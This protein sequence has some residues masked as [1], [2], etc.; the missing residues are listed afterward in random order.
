MK[1]I[2]NYSGIAGLVLISSLFFLFIS[3]NKDTVQNNPN[4]VISSQLI[5][6]SGEDANAATKTTLSGLVTSWIATTDK[7]GIYS[8]TARTQTGGGGSSIVNA[9]F[10]AAGSGASSNFNGTMYWGAA[11]TSHTFYAYYPWVSGTAAST[12][13]PVSLPSAQTQSAAGNNA[14]IGALDFMVATPVTVTSQ[15]NTDATSGVNLKYNHLFTV[16]EFQI[17]GSGTLKAVKLSAS[18]TLAFSG[19]TI[20]ITQAIPAAG[21]AYTF[22]SQT[23]TSTQTVVTLTTP[24]TLTATNADTK[25]YMVINPGT[26]TGNCL[27][28]ISTDGTTW[29][30]ISKTA[31]AGGFLRGNKYIVSVDAATATDAVVDVEGN[32]YTTVT[33]GTQI[34]MAQ[35][36]KTT[37]YNDGSDIPNVTVNGTWGSQTQGAY[38]WYNNDAATYK[39]TYGA[40]YNWYTADNNASTKVASNGGKNI[41]PTGWHV[42]SD[43]EWITLTNFLGGLNVA[44]G[45][46]KE[47]GTTHWSDPNTGATNSSGFTALPGGFRYYDDGTFGSIGYHSYWL[48]TSLDSNYPYRPYTYCASYNLNNFSRFN[49]YKTLG[50]YVRCLKNND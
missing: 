41:C 31:L 49:E 15:A 35:N 47:T 28:G 43:A 9:E 3:C 17:K 45:K 11:N 29:K 39:A 4:A 24:A 2:I 42:P 34:W 26:Q 21:V 20:N 48:S 40:L 14:H 37:K 10:T 32:I 33:I 38:C 22:A 27:I 23:G 18:N 46:L 1:K 12:V 8:S 6:I 16:I 19:G 44:G 7:V 50:C 25:I 5:K 36:L 13:V 30:Y